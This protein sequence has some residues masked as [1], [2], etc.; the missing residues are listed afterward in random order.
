MPRST[1]RNDPWL[2]TML[3]SVPA[4]T[5]SSQRYAVLRSRGC[6]RSKVV[7]VR[8]GN[9]KSMTPV[10]TRWTCKSYVSGPG[11]D[12]TPTRFQV[13]VGCAVSMTIPAGLLSAVSVAQAGTATGPITPLVPVS[14]LAA[15]ASTRQKALPVLS[16]RRTATVSVVSTV[17]TMG[18]TS[19]L[20]RLTRRRYLTG[21]AVAGTV[22][23]VHAN[24]GVIDVSGPA[25][26]SGAVAVTPP[27][28]TA[29]AATSGRP[30]P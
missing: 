30:Q 20:S 14:P 11:G 27:G 1:T 16:A 29:A 3:V 17:S 24:V 15:V 25:D 13:N 12:D 18:A 7:S 8:P 4:C 2:R 23:T 19:V 6:G 21:V 22:P 5:T 26:G 28:K 10:A 9:V